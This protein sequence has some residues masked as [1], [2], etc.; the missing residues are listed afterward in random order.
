MVANEYATY[1]DYYVSFKIKS[2]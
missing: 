1:D 2:V